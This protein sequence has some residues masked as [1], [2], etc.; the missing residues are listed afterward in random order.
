MQVCLLNSN[1]PVGGAEQQLIQ[2]ARH[3][4]VLDGRITV[5]LL[6]RQGVWLKELPSDVTVHWISERFPEG[7]RMKIL[8]SLQLIGAAVRD[9]TDDR[10]RL[11]GLQANAWG[12]APG[13]GMQ[14]ACPLLAPA[15]GPAV[16][17]PPGDPEET[18]RGGLRHPLLQRRHA[19]QA[20]YLL[21][22]RRKPSRFFYAQA[23]R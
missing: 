17:R 6:G 23:D 22:L 8:W 21:G 20:Q 3:W 4:P 9:Q 16:D 13:A 14:P 10:R 2:L 11:I 18:G 7:S 1:L 15:S 19:P 5:T 12:T